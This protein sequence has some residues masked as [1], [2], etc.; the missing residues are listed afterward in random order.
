MLLNRLARSVM[1]KQ[2][3]RSIPRSFST[4]NSA[5]AGLSPQQEELRVAVQ[6][7][8]N[9]ELAPRAN[10]IDKEN[11]FP[12][13]MWRKLGDMGLLGV[14]APPEYGGL[15]LGYF[16]H[17]MV[18]EEI[19]R[20]SGSVALSYGAHSNLCV[21]QIVRNGNE[22]QK[23]KY[24]PK[25]ISGEHVG[26]LAMSEPG[27][28]S[29]V[30]SMKLRAERKGD[31][32]VLNGDK[33]WITNG[34][35]A[36]VLV[37][38]AKTKPEAGPQGITAFLIEKGFEG[39]STGPKFDK[40]GMRGSNTCQLFFDNCKVPVE[41]VLGEVNKGVYVLMSGLDLERLVL[42]GGP[43]GLMQAALDVVVPYVHER[44][45]FNK[46]IGEFQL[47][48]GKLAD[49]Y[50]KMN[51]SRAYVYAV[52]RACDQGNISNKDC[53]GV[54]LYS[55]E[56]ATE[57]ALDAI[58]CLGGNGYTNE[59]PTGRILRDAKLYEIGAGTKVVNMDWVSNEEVLGVDN[60]DNQQNGFLL[61]EPLSAPSF[62]QIKYLIEIAKQQ[63]ILKEQ[64]IQTAD[65]SIIFAPPPPLKEEE[66][67]DE[68]KKGEMNT[69]E[70]V[71]DIHSEETVTTLEAYAAADGIDL[72][73]MSPKE[74]RQLRN[75]ISARNFRVRRKEYITSLE[76]QVAEHKKTMKE[77][78]QRL[79]R[80][81]DENKAL[82]KEMDMLKRQNQQLQQQ[83]Q[84][85]SP[86][87]SSSLPKH[88]IN[89][90]ISLLGTKPT[91]SY[92]QQQDHHCILVSNALMPAWDYE[93]IL[94]KKKPTLFQQ[95]AGHFLFLLIQSTLLQ[96]SKAKKMEYLY[97]TLIQA[98]LIQNSTIDQSFLWSD[99][100]THVI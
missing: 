75:K 100:N 53:A 22:T 1:N 87:S 23:Q 78:K 73:K 26:A 48:Q 41:N 97:D 19:S 5:I 93:S 74:R 43:L 54:I 20:A 25:L 15:G 33:F 34:P 37:V 81:E 63:I 11:E 17:T 56:R 90:D 72:K 89:K 49:M 39:F 60:F 95:L 24:L 62:E 36:D 52:G 79:S 68:N 92:R 9:V 86:R 51:A 91:D 7:W 66:K 70:Q 29:D 94:A 83:Q 45:Q 10:A 2:W 71:N 88:N 59:Y 38:Y 18:M 8:V 3:T 44:R 58:Q 55:A 57:V 28:G 35:D 96:E 67:A 99:N 82:Q 21:N 85:A 50:T 30:V 40:L 14:T 80:V 32:Y 31:H 98:S 61:Q 13:D 47:I 12:M 27:S 64:E 6:D 77:L 65:P 76:E 84:P 16:E 46:P 4:Y 69:S 42:S